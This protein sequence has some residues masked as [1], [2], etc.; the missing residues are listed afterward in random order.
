MKVTVLNKSKLSFRAY[1]RNLIMFLCICFSINSNA[2]EKLSE[3]LDKYNK[4]SIP[5]ITAETL[6][7][8]HTE[9]IIFDARELEEYKVS[10]IKNALY[11]GY[12]EFE[13]E[14]VTQKILDKKQPIVVYCSLG[15]RSEDIAEQLKK[16]GYTNIKNLY[17]GIFEW[18]NKGFH[19]YNSENK[20]TENVHAFSKTWSK[21]LKKGVRYFPDAIKDDR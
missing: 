6:D 10:H 13:V 2:Q 8:T 3:V 17:G 12:N 15:V 4:G 16:A 7:M 1:V 20:R 18:K 11:V 5:Y 9:T 19:V 14:T 21:W